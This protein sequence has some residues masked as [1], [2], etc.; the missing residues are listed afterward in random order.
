MLTVFRAVVLSVATFIQGIWDL[1][2][3]EWDDDH[4]KWDS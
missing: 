1:D 4:R 3:T 2:A